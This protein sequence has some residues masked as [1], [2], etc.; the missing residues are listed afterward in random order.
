[1]VDF[2]QGVVTHH[3]LTQVLKNFNELRFLRKSCAATPDYISL[4]EGSNHGKANQ[5]GNATERG[6][7]ATEREWERVRG[8]RRDFFIIKKAFGLLQCFPMH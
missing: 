8:E 6:E 7:R 1:M 3:S 2:D 4:D 5:R